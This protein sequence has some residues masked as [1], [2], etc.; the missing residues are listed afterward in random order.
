M[1]TQAEAHAAGPECI[2]SRTETASGCHVPGRVSPTFLTQCRPNASGCVRSTS[3]DVECKSD[4]SPVTIADK[5]AEVAMREIIERTVP[6]HGIFGEEHGLKW[7]SGAGSK[8]MWV[9]DPIDGTKSFITGA[10]DRF[11]MGV[12][13][14]GACHVKHRQGRVGRGVSS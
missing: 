10:A 4:D 5:Q 7:G 8:Y 1:H 3:F 12:S 13:D 14:S 2:L 9:L 6:E 11:G